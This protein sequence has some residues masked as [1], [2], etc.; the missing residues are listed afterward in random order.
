MRSTLPSVSGRQ[1]GA[2]KQWINH[3]PWFLPRVDSWHVIKI[4]EQEQLDIYKLIVTRFYS[5]EAP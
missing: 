4:K 5:G 1:P 2:G 3:Q